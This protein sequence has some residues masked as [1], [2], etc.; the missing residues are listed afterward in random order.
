MEIKW[1]GV[2]TTDGRRKCIHPEHSSEFDQV[3]RIVSLLICSP[4][5]Y[6]FPKVSDEGKTATFPMQSSGS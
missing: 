3:A 5:G 6:F 1:L 4:S 2:A